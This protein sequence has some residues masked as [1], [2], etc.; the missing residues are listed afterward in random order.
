MFHKLS[1]WLGQGITSANIFLIAK[2]STGLLMKSEEFILPILPR[3][4]EKY[5][6]A[7]RVWEVVDIKHSDRDILMYVKPGW[8]VHE[9][10]TPIPSTSVLQREGWKPW[11]T[12]RGR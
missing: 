5:E 12:S 11:Q 10:D 3:I 1:T 6:F 2:G 8:F 7:G 4:G 9:A